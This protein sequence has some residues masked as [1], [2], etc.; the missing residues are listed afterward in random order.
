MLRIIAHRTLRQAPVARARAFSRT[1]PARSTD[2]DPD[3][4]SRAAHVPAALTTKLEFVESVMPDG[5]RI[6]VYSV[7]DGDG[8]ILDGAEMPEVSSISRCMWKK[9]TATCAR[10]TRR[11]QGECMYA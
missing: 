11:L 8:N 3:T 1:A 9:L 2:D 10:S 5:G 4:G 7:L 6:P